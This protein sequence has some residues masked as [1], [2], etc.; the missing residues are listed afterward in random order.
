M[1]RCRRAVLL[2]AFAL[3]VLP[4]S[5]VWANTILSDDVKALDKIDHDIVQPRDK[6]PVLKKQYERILS[7]AD[8]ETLA[9]LS[10]DDLLAFFQASRT[11]SFYAKEPAYARQMH[12]AFVVLERRRS[13]T[14]AL[15]QQMLDAYVLSR[16][17][18]EARSFAH[19]SANATL[20]KLPAFTDAGSH[21]SPTLW[22][23]SDDGATLTRHDFPLTQ[24]AR[25]IVVSSPGCHFSRQASAAIAKDAVLSDLMAHHSTWVIP[26]STVPF[27][28]VAKWNQEHSAWPMQ[29]VYSDAEW[30]S[31]SSW[32]TPCFY[33]F[34][35]GKIVTSVIGWPGSEQLAALRA[36]FAKIGI[37]QAP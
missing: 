27:A 29:L 9:K 25:L 6:T 23:L 36:G 10:N 4:A 13:V 8:H 16:M 28:D 26:Q 7:K 11:L 31:I 37:G 24:D 35:D 17:L 22:R 33:F 14:L 30:P 34:R 20:V 15:R 12:R 21:H 5:H 2:L 1:N 3:V 32:A 18:D 19:E